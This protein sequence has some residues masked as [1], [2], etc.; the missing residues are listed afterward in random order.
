M[1]V[2]S[3]RESEQTQL[4]R[5]R[6]CAKALPETVFNNLAHVLTIDLLHDAF[7]AISGSK[8][9]G[10]DK[11]T[12]ALFEKELCSN[13]KELHKRIRSGHYRPQAA[14]MVNIPKEDGSRRPLAISCFE[15]KLVQWAVSKI[16]EAIYEPMFL[17][18]SYGF[19]P[20]HNCHEALRSLM[21]STYSCKDGA[22]IE[23]DIRKCFNRIPHD[24]MLPFL[25]AKITDKRFLSLARKLM[26]SPILEDGF[27]K[28][29]SLGCP[30]GSIV[31]PI[32]C[33][34]FLH[35][36]M[37]E[38]FCAVSKTHLKGKAELIRYADDMVFVFEYMEDAQRIFSVLGKR[39]NKYGLEIHEAKSAL[40]PSGSKAAKRQ[41]ELGLKMPSFMFLGFTCYWGRARRGFWRLKLTSR[42]DRYTETL[43]RLREHIKK[44]LV[45]K[46]TDALIRSVI[47]RVKGWINYHA[48][49]DN[50][51]RVSGFL[52]DVHYI[53]LKWFNRRSQR[54]SMNWDNLRLKLKQ[55][56]FPQSFKVA[57]MY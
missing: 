14:R 55:M 37:D 40:I 10:I 4:D 22:L 20:E 30:Q 32:L 27:A 53:L 23:I 52:Y 26:T 28:I 34:I 6:Y 17:P 35:H 13:I 45:T 12:K 47:R 7:V 9:I 29:Q 49:S 39:L 57:S 3:D 48:V 36:V 46:D 44:N 31:S 54:K 18:C 42:R 2:H 38:W 16:L 5:V 25:K 41:E 19:R 56:G 24:H 43:K 8:A 11:V 1:T 51:R 15:D 50:G 21:R 33:N